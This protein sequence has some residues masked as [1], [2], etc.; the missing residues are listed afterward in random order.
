MTKANVSL[1]PRV[2]LLTLSLCACAA[3]R[4]SFTPLE[5]LE[6]WGV[7]YRAD[8]IA[9]GWS[10]PESAKGESERAAEEARQVVFE[11]RVLEAPAAVLSGW[12]GDARAVAALEV[13]AGAA[14][15][16]LELDSVESLTAPRMILNEGARGTLMT[17]D[18][19]AFVESFE[20][21]GDGV[22]LVAD[23]VVAVAC[24]GFHLDVRASIAGDQVELDLVTEFVEVQL[25]DEPRPLQLPVG[26]PVHIQQPVTLVQRV[27]VSGALAH[28]RTLAVRAPGSAPGAGR[29]LLVRARPAVDER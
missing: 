7:D 13:A 4:P 25:L 24:D 2:I 23:P 10:P 16:L 15:P 26:A 11:C 17:S 9:G 27:S 22:T 19:R 5:H 14:A 28:D 6:E 18:Q 8:V 29:L 21:V 1:T 12:Q 20:V 3:P